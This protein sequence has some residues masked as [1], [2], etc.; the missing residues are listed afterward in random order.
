MVTIVSYS[1]HHQVI[2]DPETRPETDEELGEEEEEVEEVEE[3]YIE[4]R[5]PRVQNRLEFLKAN[6][7]L[8][9]RPSWTESDSKS[10]PS[11][12]PHPAPAPAP[13]LNN[14][15]L[16]ADIA[17]AHTQYSSDTGSASDQ[18]TPDTQQQPPQQSHAPAPS[19]PT[20]PL[21]LSTSTGRGAGVV[22]LVP[23]YRDIK[24]QTKLKATVPGGRVVAAA[25]LP[26][27]RLVS[28]GQYPQYQAR[29][30]GWGMK[31]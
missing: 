21:N 1:H 30:I 23:G 7:D 8:L 10:T 26:G 19:P 20:P 29:I 9:Q 4:V 22:S 24:P 27:V 12:P 15:H 5:E 28:P 25:P 16:L 2:T 6:R 3:S 13:G 14:L 18:E 11:P 31:I 17:M